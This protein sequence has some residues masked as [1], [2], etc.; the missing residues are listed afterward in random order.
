M[1]DPLNVAPR[2]R[3]HRLW[4]F[5]RIARVLAAEQSTCLRKQ[6][7]CIALNEGLDQILSIG[8]N[9][10]ERKGANICDRPMESGNCGCLHAENNCMLKLKTSEPVILVCTHSPC[11]TCAKAITIPGNV[12]KVYFGEKF[13][14][15]DE[16]IEILRRAGI[17][18]AALLPEDEHE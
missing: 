13:S 14:R 10:S 15:G 4:T 8:V 16:G 17:R 9:G 11:T 3:P 18:A 2:D 7:A 6:V 1:S 12:K 5:A